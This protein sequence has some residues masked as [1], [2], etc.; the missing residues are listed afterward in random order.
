MLR[1][2]VIEVFL[3][4]VRLNQKFE[5]SWYV[6]IFTF[7]PCPGDPVPTNSVVYPREMIP[8]ML[9]TLWELFTG[10]V[11]ELMTVLR[12]ADAEDY[13]LQMLRW[14]AGGASL[15]H[16]GAREPQGG[17]QWV[18]ARMLSLPAAFNSLRGSE[19]FEE[20]QPLPPLP[21]D[22]RLPPALPQPWIQPLFYE[23]FIQEL[24]RPHPDS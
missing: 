2:V 15:P 21:S 1:H 20:C 24:P 11:P 18:E 16:P 8:Q 14:P 3:E 5:G 13:F 9:R 7:P 10:L 17:N 23:Q 19:H 6:C 12:M 4:E 22:P